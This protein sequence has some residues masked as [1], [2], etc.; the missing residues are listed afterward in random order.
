[1]TF[2]V[3]TVLVAQLLAPLAP[4]FASAQSTSPAKA[5]VKT[6]NAAVKA[7]RSDSARADSVAKA[8][9]EAD[10][11][12]FEQQ[13]RTQRA[14]LLKGAAWADLGNRCNPGNLRVFPGAT[15]ALQQ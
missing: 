10:E 11:R 14:T 15:S 12:Y 8:L 6:T 7:P 4:H 13:L 3:R 1:M 5:P 2:V 9:L